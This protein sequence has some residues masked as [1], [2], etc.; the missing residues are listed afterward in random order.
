MIYLKSKKGLFFKKQTVIPK[1]IQ[2][3]VSYVSFNICAGLGYLSKQ[4]WHYVKNT[5]NEVYKKI[6]Y[7]FHKYVCSAYLCK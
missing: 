6:C 5:L 4:V 1:L 3:N 2:V 7:S